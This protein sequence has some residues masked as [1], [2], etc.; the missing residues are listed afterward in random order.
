MHV[1][2]VHDVHGGFGPVPTIA[3]VDAAA[4]RWL[5]LG[6][7]HCDVALPTWVTLEVGKGV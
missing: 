7:R 3:G 6:R 4:A 2:M 5:M 1:C